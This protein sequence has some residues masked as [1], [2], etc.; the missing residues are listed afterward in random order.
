MKG[1]NIIGATA[2]LAL[3]MSAQ[4]A[5]IYFGEDLNPGVSSANS[6]AANA[7]FLS[8]LSG[9][10]TEDFESFAAGQ[11][12]PFNS[13]FTGAGTA[14]FS[15]SGQI[16]DSPG[17]GRFATSGSQFLET[18]NGF[19]IDFTTAISA[20]GFFGTDIG[21]FNGQITL[22]FLSGGSTQYTVQNTIG[23]NNGSLLYWGIIDV[24]NPF[25]RITFGNTNTN[26]VFGFDDMTIGTIAQVNPVPVPAALF[27]FAPALLGF[28]GLRRKANKIA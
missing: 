5:D 8:Q 18:R 14:T 10:G 6:A 13:N 12:V 9:V 20:F 16:E 22:D 11:N 23:A 19:Q 28:F 25:T 24:L 1:L 4:S 17:A 7:S 3:S 27:M 2:L 21:D 26:D 15:G